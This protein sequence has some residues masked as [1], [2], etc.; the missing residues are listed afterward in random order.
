MPVYN[1]EFGYQSKPPDPFQTPIGRIPGFLPEAEWL[2]FRNKRVASWSQYTLVDDKLGTGF[3]KYGGWQGGLRFADGST[4]EKVYEAYRSPIFVRLL[5]SDEVEV[6]GAARP[7]GP[8]AI[9]QVEQSSGGAFVALG[10][11]ISVSNVRGYF[12]QRFKIS[13]AKGRRYRFRYIDTG[14]IR[15][16]RA[17]KPARR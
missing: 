8:G 7:V 4:K 13:G 5:G 10:A 11:P 16:S 17:A 9:V 12:R 2:A 14:V 15:Y 1:T 3:D 6:F